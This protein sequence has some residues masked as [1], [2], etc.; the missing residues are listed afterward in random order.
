MNYELWDQVVLSNLGEAVCHTLSVE[1]S[2]AT[3]SGSHLWLSRLW[4]FKAGVEG[5]KVEA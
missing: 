3:I 2:G 5:G 1:Q 4:K